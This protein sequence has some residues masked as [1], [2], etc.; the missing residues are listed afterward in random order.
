MNSIK[1]NAAENSVQLII[2]ANKAD[3]ENEREVSS[4][5]IAKKAQELNV[6][7]FETSAKNNT[8]IDEAFDTIIDKVFKNVYHR[9]K[10][11][12]IN[13]NSDGTN[14]SNNNRCC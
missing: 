4:E 1:E 7:Y 5:E 14:N 6:E 10:G 12:D 3:L 2:I 8:N 9:P 13:K 11:F